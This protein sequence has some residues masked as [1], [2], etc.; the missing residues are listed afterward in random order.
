[1]NVKVAESR[2]KG[3]CTNK[4]QTRTQAAI[5]VRFAQL[6]KRITP[7]ITQEEIFAQHQ[8]SIEALA[9]RAF[10]INR[11]ERIGSYTRGSAIKHFS[12][13]D[14]LFVLSRDEV[15]NSYGQYHSSNTLLK[16]VRDQLQERYKQTEIGKDG[17][18][19][20][21]AFRDGQHPVDVVPGYFWKAG[22]ANYPIFRIPDGGGDWMET[23]PQLQ[24]KYIAEADERSA[25]KLKGVARL[26][27]YWAQTRT[28]T[29]SLSGFHIEML[30][31]ETDICACPQTHSTAFTKAIYVLAARNCRALQDP[32]G[33]SG[34]IKAVGTE[35][36]QVTLD[37]AIQTA[38]YHCQSAMQAEEGSN[39]Q[40]ATRQWDIVFNGHFPGRR[41]L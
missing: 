1:M 36:K 35:S 15:R 18:A 38:A 29:D 28:T 24:N 27:K 2:Q 11:V 25:G 14:L 30:L 39:T 17:Q 34:Y 9:K 37:R 33:I 40:E 12:D 5:A 21:I 20:V 7:D 22:L 23:S 6:L 13:A 10:Q 31:A 4:L 3:G 19:I 26:L 41:F 16:K 8:S 32:L